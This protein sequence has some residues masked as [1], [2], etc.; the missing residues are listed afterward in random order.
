MP[1]VD[2]KV[3]PLH[4]L[5]ES[6]LMERFAPF[7]SDPR[8]VGP[9]SALVPAEHLPALARELR[10]GL[11]PA[12][13]QQ[14]REAVALLLGSFRLADLVEDRRVFQAAMA[15]ELGEYPLD[16]LHAAIRRARRRCRLL[17]SIAEM[18]ALCEDEVRPR[19]EQLVCVERMAAEH[20]RRR[21]A[22]QQPLPGA[23][24]AS[25]SPGRAATPPRDAWQLAVEELP[26]RGAAADEIA[27]FT[28]ALLAEDPAVRAGAEAR[29]AELAEA[30]QQRQEE[31]AA[32]T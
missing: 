1:P 6:T 27:A 19:R 12:S 20:A 8:L 30:A 31:A 16:A 29:Q 2:R 22:V 18:V 13:P 24:E 3:V 32:Q 4:A 7:L 23:R 17:P 26:R 10:A 21:Q 11:E 9:Q 15:E 14:A 28:V 25:R 5:P